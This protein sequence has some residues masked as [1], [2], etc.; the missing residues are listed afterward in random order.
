MLPFVVANAA[1]KATSENITVGGVSRNMLVYAPSD[2]PT[3][4][5]LLI[6][7]HGMNQ[8]AAYQQGMANWEEIADREKFVVVYPNG[9]DHS[10]D[11]SST[12]NNKDLNFLQVIIDEMSTRYNI[13]RSRV[14]LSGFSMGGM[15]TYFAANYMTDK[16][17]QRIKKYNDRFR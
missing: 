17:G 16:Y 5:P 13:N 2:L 8:D 4:A 1:S 10:W 14:Y 7:L 12:T 9:I 6:S 15:M 11:I 3:N